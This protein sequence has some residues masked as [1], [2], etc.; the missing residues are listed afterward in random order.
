[1][2][3]PYLETVRTLEKCIGGHKL[4]VEGSSCGVQAAAPF[5]EMLVPILRDGCPLDSPSRARCDAGGI[6]YSHPMALVRAWGEAEGE[7][8]VEVGLTAGSSKEEA[9]DDAFW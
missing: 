8:P 2:E 3:V 4:D 6:W 7:S 9:L 5:F 1:M